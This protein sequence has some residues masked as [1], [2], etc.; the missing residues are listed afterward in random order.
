MSFAPFLSRRPRWGNPVNLW[1]VASALLL[2]AC[3]SGDP[4][5]IGPED[6]F[7]E[8]S[9][10]IAP[11]QPSV[12]TDNSAMIPSPDTAVPG[13]NGGAATPEPSVS[14]TSSNSMPVTPELP[15]DS[16]PGVQP[17]ATPT[18]A[19]DTSGPGGEP[20]PDVPSPD[21]SDPDQPVA[22]EPVDLPDPDSVQPDANVNPNP[23]N[24][25]PEPVNPEPNTPSGAGFHVSD[26]KLLDVNGN[27]FI[28][29][30][31]N[32]PYAWYRDGAQQRMA[33]IASVGA[34]AVRVV[35]A[36]GQ[37][38]DRVSGDEVSSI[39][40]WTKANKLVAI[41]EVHDATGYNDKDGFGSS[42]S[43]DVALE[44]WKSSDVRAAIDGQE[45]Y[46]IINIANE[47]FGNEA[48]GASLWESWHA[49][50]VSD[51]RSAGLKH[52]LM[53]DAANW[54]Q[55]WESIMLNNAP[56]VFNADPDKNTIF[57]VHMYEVYD[58]ADKAWSYMETFLG[59]GLHLVVGEFAAN[60]KGAEVA[61]DAVMAAAQEYG[62]G[63][64]G[65][66][67]SGNSNEDQ[68]NELDITDMFD[69]NSL[70]P[71]GKR[72][73]EGTDGLQETAQVCT[74]FN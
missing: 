10:P 21:A 54:G 9:G 41:L 40:S 12:T 55:D 71:W 39:I 30:G 3:G 69:V 23:T 60:H 15:A 31:V 43:P 37:Q 5:N 46:V 62:V 16:G 70:T 34:N 36:S 7:T 32:D 45:A 47:P 57:A 11:L 27:E 18:V 20:D 52:T 42:Y 51:L 50:A 17:P 73:V 4:N 48:T 68:L 49:N 1:H 66:S 38:W 61:E 13:S 24:P 8:P 19:P 14:P 2:V 59:H 33:D 35:L 44:Y 26:G 56:N 6:P 22:P 65:W 29:R 74:C 53:V 72:L 64:L 58:T 67:W 28:M 63:Y 25:Q